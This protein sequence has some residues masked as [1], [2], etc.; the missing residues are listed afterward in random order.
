MGFFMYGYGGWDCNM[1][2]LILKFL[3]EHFFSLQCPG[4]KQTKIKNNSEFCDICKER[5]DFTYEPYC[6]VCG[7]TLDGILEICSKCLL[8]EKV[9]WKN[10]IAVL[11]MK[12]YGQELVQR[13]KYSN[14]I[15]LAR[16]LSK[17]AAGKLMSSDI[18]FDLITY[19]PLHWRKYFYRGYNQSKLVSKFI[20]KSTKKPCKRILSRTRYTASQ[21]RLKAEE[22]RKNLKDAFSVKNKKAILNQNILLIDDVF[23]TG[24]TLRFAAQKLLDSG[25]NSVTVFVLARR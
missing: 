16:P 12:G 10:A 6:P 25:A 17:I 22:R 18:T 2:K 20:S 24:S 14:D 21:T 15:S 8:E 13:L 4:C 3:F 11:Q 1:L 19:I 5:L 7:S 23:T 9:S